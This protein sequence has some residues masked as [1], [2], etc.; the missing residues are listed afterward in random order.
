MNDDIHPAFRAQL[1]RMASPARRHALQDED[2]FVKTPRGRAEVS[3]RDSALPR[4]LGDLLLLID[5]RRSIGDLRRTLVRFR[6]LDE[7][8]DM[9][10]TKGLIAPLPRLPGL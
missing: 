6:S 10:R 3:R 5:G 1:L 4:R 8:L 7:C 2:V 9:L